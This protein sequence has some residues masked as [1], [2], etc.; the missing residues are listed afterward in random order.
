MLT[1]QFNRKHTYLRLAVTD[2]CNLRC[3]YCMPAEGIDFAAKAALLTYEEMLRLTGLLAKYGLNKVRITGGEPLARRDIGF[4]LK[5]LAAQ[6]LKIHMTSNAVLLDQHLEQLVNL[7]LSGLNISLDSLRPERFFEIT[8]RDEFE[9]VWTNLQKALDAGIPTKINMVTMAGTNDDEILDFAAL[10]KEHALSVRFIEAM[11]F[12]AGD[13]N[14]EVYLSAAAIEAR[15]RAAHPRMQLAPTDRNAAT[16]RYVVPGWRGSLGV[17]PAYSRS[18]CGQCNRIRLTPKGTLLN[19]LYAREGLELLPLLRQGCHDE[20]LIQLIEKYL[21]NKA[22][23]GK[24][25][26]RLAGPST[27]YDAMTTIGG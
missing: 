22:V 4:L 10:A 17:I 14:R 24:E 1:D 20:E 15:L 3:R 12:N 27:A 19:C 25:T 2:R 13:G 6:G 5:G 18:L 21:F 11:P 16:N 23:D 8:R 26:E 7:P 9:R